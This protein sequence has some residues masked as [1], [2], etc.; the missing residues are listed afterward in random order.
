MTK[1][2]GTDGIRGIA[3]REPITT[4][5][6]NALGR[7]LVAWCRNRRHAPRVVIGRDTRISGASLEDAVA[8]GICASG[9]AAAMAGVIPTPGVAYL[10]RE[11]KAG[12]GVVISAS[13]NPHDYNG[14]KVFSG[15]GFKLT[16]AEEGEIEGLMHAG[17]AVRPGQGASQPEKLQH[18]RDSYLQ[19]LGKAAEDAGSLKDLTVVLD[20]ANGAASVVAPQLFENLCGAVDVMF[21]GPDGTNINDGCGSEHTG[22]LSERVLSTGAHAGL[23]FDGDADRL[24]AVDESGRTLTGDQ[25]IAICARMLKDRG[26]LK[27]SLVVTTVMSNVGLR[28]AL[29]EMDISHVAAPV[30][31]RHVME[32]MRVGGAVLGGEASGHTIFSMHHTTGDGLLTA[33]QLLAALKW[34][35]RPLSQLAGFMTLFPQALVNVPV[36]RKPPLPQVSELAAV[37]EAVEAELGDRG[38]VLV[39]YSGTEPLCRVMVEGEDES[40]VRELADRIART[41]KEHL[42]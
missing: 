8:E 42:G 6:G 38:R 32:E 19:F 4:E 22:P 26:E 41:V 39:R 28:F 11:Q 9:G 3:G 24:I 13:H 14:F 27:N 33:I 25:L 15:S 7:A 37:V 20:C 5:T 1:L 23:A 31:D 36:T 18:A 21:A 10:A 35:D 17:P 34:F 30:G 29:Q 2:F 40:R 16:D 12:A